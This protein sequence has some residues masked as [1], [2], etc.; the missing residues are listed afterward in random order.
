MF[1][2]S[3]SFLL[4]MISLSVSGVEDKVSHCLF[5]FYH[6][7]FKT[8]TA[9][10]GKYAGMQAPFHF[11]A[12][13]VKKKPGESTEKLITIEQSKLHHIQT[14]FT[15][16]TKIRYWWLIIYYCQAYFEHFSCIKGLWPCR[17]IMLSE[18]S[19]VWG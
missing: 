2:L 10:L 5:L 1:S 14:I 18:I 15:Y 13:I 8:I 11:E 3:M 4:C 9:Q 19:S 6:F 7:T 17:S 16:Q 12:L